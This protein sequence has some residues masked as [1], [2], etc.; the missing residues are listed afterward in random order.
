MMKSLKNAQVDKGAKIFDRQT[1]F[2]ED[3][4]TLVSSWLA[5]LTQGS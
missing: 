2:S 3:L 1:L 5:S 4:N